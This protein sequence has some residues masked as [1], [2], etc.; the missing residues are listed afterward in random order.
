MIFSKNGTNLFDKIKIIIKPI[1]IG[2]FALAV[3]V[4][5]LMLINMPEFP[6]SSKDALIYRI[7]GFTFIFIAFVIPGA[8]VLFTSF[9][10]IAPLFK[11]HRWKSTIL[12]FLILFSLGVISSIGIDTLHSSEFKN[13]KTKYDAVIKLNQEE[14]RRA[15]EAAKVAELKLKAD[16][17]AADQADKTKAAELKAEAEKESSE[18]S[19]ES[20]EEIEKAAALKT[21]E[22][23]A[24]PVKTLTSQTT[25]QTATSQTS[26]Q[27]TVSP[28]TRQTT[29]IT[30]TT[31]I[32]YKVFQKEDISLGG[33][34]RYAWHVS[35]EGNPNTDQLT[36]LSESIVE[37]AKKE[38]SF[39]AIVVGLYDYEEFYGTGYTL[40]KVTYAPD[41]DWAKASDVQTG[42][43][44]KMDYAYELKT[45]DWSKQLTK[46]EAEIFQAWQDLYME[47]SSPT[48]IA[49]ETED[50]KEIADLYKI[51]PEKVDQIL[52]KHLAW[53]FQ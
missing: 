39:N 47:I 37:I 33:S 38:K 43:Y 53:M 11:L 27:T 32:K 45:I 36:K 5:L 3:F 51:R 46:E 18:Q 50:S 26:Q 9:R 14:E 49:D 34:K 17:I 20:I 4:S 40:G 29:E 28:T 44:S 8:L 10:K 21:A 24:I 19:A 31:A 15:K 6:V 7:S 52:Q 13:A 48:V 22:E 23:K 16:K 25:Q 42:D 30:T 2:Y 35:V 41:G 1:K 12:G